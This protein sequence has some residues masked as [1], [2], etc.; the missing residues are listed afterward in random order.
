MRVGVVKETAAG[1]RRVAL[2]P[3]VVK[4]LTAKGVD[5]VVEPGAGDGA[6]L[7]DEHFTE[8][9]ATL[10]DPWGADVVVKVAPPGADEIGKVRDGSTL[11]GFLA[12]LTNPETGQQLGAKN[13][14]AFAMEAIPRITC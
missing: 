6:L 4:K 14:N 13:V 10:G 8:A 2:V 3:E 7:P 9:G 12:P 11:I 5:V 1:E